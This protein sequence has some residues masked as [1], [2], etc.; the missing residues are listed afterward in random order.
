MG[1]PI[2]A[3][4]LSRTSTVSAMTILRKPARAS[5]R[6]GLESAGA[7]VLPTTSDLAREEGGE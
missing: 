4:G 7:G 2:R 1:E 5:Q 6:S 3:P